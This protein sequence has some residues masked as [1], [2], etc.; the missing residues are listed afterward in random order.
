MWPETGRTGKRREY[1]L[2]LVTLTFNISHPTLFFHLFFHLT[3]SFFFFFPPIS[4][5]CF[6]NPHSLIAVVQNLLLTVSTCFCHLFAIFHHHWKM[7]EDTLKT[8]S[9]YAW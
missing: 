5:F 8:M 2:L 6:F 9:T 1:K 7:K 4:C 3:L